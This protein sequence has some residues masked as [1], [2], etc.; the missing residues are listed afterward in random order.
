VT[1]ADLAELLRGTAAKVLAEHG[2]DPSVL[3]AE[4]KVERPRNPEHG[5]YASN[6]AMQIGKKA[7]ANPRELAG[8][9]AEALTAKARTTATPTRSPVRR[10]TW[11]SFPPTPPDRS[12][13]AALGGRPSAMR[14]AG[15]WPPAARTSPGSTTSTITALRST[16]SPG[17]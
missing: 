15:C 10:S 1:P 12:I 14:S 8:W 4:L 6:I 13:S 16:V 17:R 3:P 7:G 11:S 9:L 5:D 2:L